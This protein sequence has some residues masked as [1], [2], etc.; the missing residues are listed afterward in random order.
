MEKINYW[1]CVIWK[2]KWKIL[3]IA[4]ISLAVFIGIPLI[5]NWA[6]TTPARFSLFEMDD[7][8]DTALLFY[9]SV[10]SC[11]G[12]VILGIVSW[13]QNKNALKMNKELMNLQSSEYMPI[14]QLTEFAG[15]HMFKGLTEEKVNSTELVIAEMNTRDN[16]IIV[17]FLMHLST[18]TLSNKEFVFSR[19]YE[20]HFRYYGKAVVSKT[21]C[22]TITFRNNNFEKVFTPNNELKISLS[23]Q[24]DFPLYIVLSSHDKPDDGN[25]DFSK[26]IHAS[27][28]VIEFLFTTLDN[29]TFSEILTIYKHYADAPDKNFP[30]GKVERLVSSSFTIQKK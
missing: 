10:L 16:G 29:S 13:N 30:D 2:L 12:T 9:G 22:K 18:E 27:Q 5:I 21:C 3:L 26:C 24:Q 4:L 15:M 17:C 1:L 19:A 23:D 11:V 25:A 20:F 28:I 8:S 6:F 7:K 14:L